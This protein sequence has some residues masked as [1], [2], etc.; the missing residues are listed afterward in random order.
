[1]RIGTPLFQARLIRDS[2]VRQNPYAF[3]VKPLPQLTGNALT[4]YMKMVPN[5][6]AKFG[7]DEQLVYSVEEIVDTAPYSHRLSYDAES[8]LW[9]LLWWAIQIQPDEP[10]S[11]NLIPGGLWAALTAGQGKNDLRGSTFVLGSPAICHPDYRRLDKLLQSLFQQLSG[12]QE[13]VVLRGKGYKHKVIAGKETPEDTRIQPDYLHEAFQR[14]ILAFLVRHHKEPFMKKQISPTRRPKE[15][16]AEMAQS[17]KTPIMAPLPAPNKRK[18]AGEA[19]NAPPNKKP[20]QSHKTEQEGTVK[21][22]G[23]GKGKETVKG[24]V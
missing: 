13:Y 18:V 17:T 12:Y 20:K 4:S 6:I 3:F 16:G 22:K 1:M 19:P 14:H 21:G 11:T 8:I 23:K 15:E 9:L 24:K 2:K 5:R 10:N 7:K